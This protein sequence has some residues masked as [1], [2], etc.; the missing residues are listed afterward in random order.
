MKI[1]SQGDID[2]MMDKE[3]LTIFSIMIFCIAGVNGG[4][5]SMYIL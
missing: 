1:A 2:T 4:R 5:K 3:K